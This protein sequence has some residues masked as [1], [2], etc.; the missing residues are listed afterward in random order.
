MDA[1]CN[2]TLQLIPLRA[3][4]FNVAQQYFR[5]RVWS[6]CSVHSRG[7]GY[8]SHGACRGGGSSC[9]GY[10]RCIV[11]GNGVTF[12]GTFSASA[13]A[14]AA[15]SVAAAAAVLATAA[16]NA[17]AAAAA[18]EAA[19][20]V[21]AVAHTAADPTSKAI[22]VYRAIWYGFESRP[23]WLAVPEFLGVGEVGV[24]E[25]LGVGEV[26]VAGLALHVA[27]VP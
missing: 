10:V 21:P 9:H 8:K 26:E 27:T 3:S 13:V 17:T 5:R 14:V 2:P 16:A 25:F 24:P 4:R 1:V 23:G 19:G 6:Q 22:P 18:E 7:G 20:G 12:A 15:A 11:A